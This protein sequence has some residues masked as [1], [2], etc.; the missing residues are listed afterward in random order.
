MQ[1]TQVSVLA[2]HSQSWFLLLW[3]GT[4]AKEQKTGFWYVT[5]LPL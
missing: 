2:A 4:T 3:S 5:A 1:A